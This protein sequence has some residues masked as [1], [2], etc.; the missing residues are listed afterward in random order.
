MIS[1]TIIKDFLPEDEFKFIQN[2]YKNF[3]KD[4]L[5][6]NS[7]FSRYE[8][9]GEE[10]SFKLLNSKIDQARKVFKSSTLLPTYSF[11]TEYS[12]NASLMK[13]KDMSACTYT[14]DLCLY[15]TEPWDLWVENKSYTLLENQALA[16]Y[17][18]SQEH[19]REKFPNPENQVVSMIFLHYAEPD[20]WWFKK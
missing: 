7:D 6:F 14:L 18:E 19:W 11:F 17:G 5:I 1:P 3:D 15:Q 8:I 4:K 20:H 2:Y 16:Y 9:T 13:H 12:G 10:V